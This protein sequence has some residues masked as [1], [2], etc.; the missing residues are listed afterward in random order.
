MGWVLF[1]RHM[2]VWIILSLHR[3]TGPVYRVRRARRLSTT[4]MI[5]RAVWLVPVAFSVSVP[6]REFVAIDVGTGA[7]SL[8]GVDARPQV[9]CAAARRQLCLWNLVMRWRAMRLALRRRHGPHVRLSRSF[10]LCEWRTKSLRFRILTV[11]ITLVLD[12]V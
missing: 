5:A 4:R 8:V 12:L 3:S 10:P 11:P 7:H 6:L 2:V 1:A 9:R